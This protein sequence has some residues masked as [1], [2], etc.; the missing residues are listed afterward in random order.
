MVKRPGGAL[1]QAIEID[2][3]SSRTISTQLA[4][5]L[6]NLILTRSLKAGERLPA[7]RTLANDLGIAR[8]T[9]IETFEQLASE[10][11]IESRVGA[12]TFVS[13]ALNAERPIPPEHPGRP[14]AITKVRLARSMATAA[15]RFVPRLPHAPRP[16]TTAMPAFD[17][18]PLAQWARL[19]AK[20]WRG[21]RH[22]VLGYG[23]AQGYPPLRQAIAAHLR[24]NRGIACDWQQVFIVAGAQQAFQLIGS[25]LIDP[26]DAVWFENPGAIGARNSLIFAGAKLVPVPVD[27]GGLAVEHAWAAAPRFRAAFVTP[28]H[29]QPLGA[30]MSL[31]RR[32]ALLRAAEAA[33]AWIIEDDYD[34]EFCFAGRPLPTLKGIDATG[35]VIYV[36]TFSKSLFPSLRLGFFLAPPSLVATFG[37]A[38]EA[39]LPG[40]PTSLQ[41]TVSDFI[42]EG[43]FATHIRRMR[44]LYA[45]RH[46][47]FIDAAR[48][49]LSEWLDVVPTNTGLHTI[50]LLRGGL[51]GTEVSAAAAGRG[52]TVAPISRFCI[53]PIATEGLVLGF[54]GTTPTQIRAGVAALREVLAA[55]AQRSRP[56]RGAG[57]SD[58]RRR[59]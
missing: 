23:E 37:T 39:F 16:F 21:Q 2:R 54:S 30:K 36:G 46:Q 20:H 33:Q 48:S 59:A 55:C 24:A 4:L 12:G 1:L 19:A 40:V 49:Q 26:G 44:K 11:L 7:S 15:G 42:D 8:T 50:G 10:G 17:A 6:R 28:A 18:F 58:R 9:V 14:A 56:A 43:L 25:T 34:G 41:A 27:D 3:A 5:A 47:L 35:R 51:T 45:E 22:N 13:Q 53:D 52:L 29:Q 38:L 32:F 31:E 57:G